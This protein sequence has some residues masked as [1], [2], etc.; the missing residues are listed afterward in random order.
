VCYIH[1]TLVPTTSVFFFVGCTT[2]HGNY[3]T[4]YM[5]S[6]PGVKRVSRGSGKINSDRYVAFRITT[7]VKSFVPIIKQDLTLIYYT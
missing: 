3:L 5:S 2:R 6:F 1:I 4:S 7:E